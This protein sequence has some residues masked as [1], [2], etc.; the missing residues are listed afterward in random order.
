MQNDDWNRTTSVIRFL[1]GDFKLLSVTATTFYTQGLMGL[2]FA[3]FFGWQKLP[4]LTLLV[5]VSDF[6]VFARILLDH[7]GL[8]KIKAVFISLILFFTPLH[9]YSAIGFMTENYVLLFTLLALYFFLSFE[10]TSKRK[11]FVLFN[12]MGLL[13]FFAK[14]SGI[15]INAS[16]L[17]YFLVKR[18]F[19]EALIQLGFLVVLL[20]YYSFFFPKTDEMEDKVFLRGILLSHLLDFKYAYS[21]VYGIILVTSSFIVPVLVYFVF[22]TY[23][24]FRKSI[25]IIIALL[26]SS[27]ACYFFLNRWFGPS[28]ISWSE[29]PYFENTF[30]RTG[31]FPRSILGTKYQF[32]GNYKLFKYWDI[33][34]KVSLALAIP[35]LFL[36]L[37]KIVNIYSISI[38]GYVILMIFVKTFFDRYN[39]PLIPLFILFLLCLRVPDAF[40]GKVLLGFLVPFVLITGFLSTQMGIDFVLSNN[41]IWGRSESLVSQGVRP[42]KIRAT[43]AWGK[44]YGLCFPNDC[45]YL[46]S[47]DNFERNSGLQINYKLVEEK[48]LNFPGSMFINPKVYLYAKK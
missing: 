8:P 34:A 2:L 7:F 24:H 20:G 10:K 1:A 12:L 41:Y 9:M 31:F 18:K 37:T 29:Y 11:H 47:Y 30:E 26:A 16:A 45:Q 4:I 19:K 39:L 25:I 42:N 13:A 40:T 44:L 21:I 6:Y 5:S 33:G 38:V 23:S 48:D 3:K 22:S 15:L 14:Q 35:C 32:K 28:K 27:V 36:Y 43:M 46:F 17:V